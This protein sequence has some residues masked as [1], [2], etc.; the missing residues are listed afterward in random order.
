MLVCFT[1]TAPRHATILTDLA[2]AASALDA[3]TTGILFAALVDD[4]ASALDGTDAY[5]GSIMGEAASAG[6]NVDAT[7]IGGGTVYATFDGVNTNVTISGGGLI[8]THSGGGTYNGARSTM[9]KNSGKWYFEVTKHLQ[10]FPH[11]VVGILTAAGTYTDIVWNWTNSLAD[12]SFVNPNYDT[13]TGPSGTSGANLS[14]TT[15]PA[16]PEIIGVAVDL[17]NWMVWFRVAPAGNWNGSGTAN[18]ATNIGGI[19]ISVLNTT[20][21]APAVGFNGGAS[22]GEVFTGN[23]GAS[24]FSGT[25]PSGFNAGWF[26]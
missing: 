15:V 19:N 9:Q 17:T 13:I 25:V 2:E 1:S 16:D 12:R 5:L 6:D 14:G 18:P 21:V 8:V 24:T 10:T 26:S 11:N 22:S 20:T 7:A 23:F 3:P 4:P